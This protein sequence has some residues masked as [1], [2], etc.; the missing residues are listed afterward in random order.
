[1]SVKE[2]EN[3]Q[4][5]VVIAGLEA[6]VCASAKCLD[7]VSHTNNVVMEGN[8]IYMILGDC[9]MNTVGNIIACHSAI[10]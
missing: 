9:V 7:T 6:S 3:G 2:Q 8:M 5:A 4:C 10:L 1:M